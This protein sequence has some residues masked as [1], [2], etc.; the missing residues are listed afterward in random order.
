MQPTRRMTSART[1]L[2]LILGSSPMVEGIPGFFVA[3]RYGIALL[4]LMAVVFAAR[5]IIIYVALYVYSISGL[6][7]VTL[8]T[9]ERGKMIFGVFIT[10]VGVVF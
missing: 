10:I 6:Q 2:L 3:G 1:A 4:V 9:F 8:G 5:T 7:R